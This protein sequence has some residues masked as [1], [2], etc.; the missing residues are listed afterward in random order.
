MAFRIDCISQIPRQ[1][2]QPFKSIYP[3]ANCIRSKSSGFIHLT[4]IVS[5]NA[6]TAITTTIKPTTPVFRTILKSTFY[7]FESSDSPGRSETNVFPT[8]QRRHSIKFH[9]IPER[10][11]ETTKL[12]TAVVYIHQGC[13][14]YC[15]PSRCE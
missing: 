15:L 5:I 10:G 9:P 13:C 4:F 8:Q 2:G 1:Q 7:L 6:P 11:A 3:V 12:Q 14:V